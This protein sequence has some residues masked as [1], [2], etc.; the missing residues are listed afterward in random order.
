MR[1]R[2]PAQTGAAQAAVKRLW[3]SSAR[4]VDD[5]QE[6]E[7]F[8]LTGDII[9]EHIVRLDRPT[10]LAASTASR[11]QQQTIMRGGKYRSNFVLSAVLLASLDRASAKGFD[12]ICIRWRFIS[13]TASFLRVGLGLTWPVIFTSPC[14]FFLLFTAGSAGATLFRIERRRLVLEEEMDERGT[15]SRKLTREWI[16]TSSVGYSVCTDG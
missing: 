5:E 6:S 2:A 12:N 14:S 9:L 3:T 4:W 10:I 16:G 15:W 1:T 8:D 11:C 7:R 13:G